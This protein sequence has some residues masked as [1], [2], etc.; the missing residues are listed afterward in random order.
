MARLVRFE[1]PWPANP[2]RDPLDKL[3]LI[4]TLMIIWRLAGGC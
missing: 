1:P 4:M 2:P 3:A